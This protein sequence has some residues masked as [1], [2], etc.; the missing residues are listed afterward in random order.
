[1]ITGFMSALY[2]ADTSEATALVFEA[3]PPD[4][5]DGPDANF[6]WC[7]ENEWPRSTRQAVPMAR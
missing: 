5:Q 6:W 1:M 4:E 2:H 7:H 3:I